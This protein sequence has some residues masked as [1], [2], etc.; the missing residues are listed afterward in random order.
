M[1][2]RVVTY[3]ATSRDAVRRW[4]REHGSKVEA[5]HGLVRVDFIRRDSPPRAGAIMY[6]E[7]PEDLRQYRN[8]RLYEWLREKIDDEWVDGSQP[9]RE[10]VFRVME[11]PF[12]GL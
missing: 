6:F 3:G 12:P 8:S 2:A 5:A 11:V 1:I 4:H 10:L 7:S 9:V